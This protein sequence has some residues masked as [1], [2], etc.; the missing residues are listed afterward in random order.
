LSKSCGSD[1]A[2]Q[3]RWGKDHWELLRRRLASLAAAPSLEDMTNV[4]G[5]C[6]ALGGDR[7]G[8]FAVSLW[9]PYRLVFRPNHDPVPTVPDGG[10]DRSK[11]TA[12]AI[13]EIV[14]YH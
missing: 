7:E 4:P 5:S 10:I 1:T 13:E 14:D 11:V 8:S 9:G 3:K 2:G 6:H 12:I